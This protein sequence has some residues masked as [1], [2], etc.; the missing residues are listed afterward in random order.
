MKGLR[1]ISTC[2]PVSQ[3]LPSSGLAAALCVLAF[4]RGIGAQAP[5]AADDPVLVVGEPPLKQSDVA[6]WQRLV[7]FAFDATLSIDQRQLLQDRLVARWEG[8]GPRAR[9][10]VLRAKQVWGEVSQAIGPQR[11]VMRLALR[12]RMV[13]EAETD[14]DESA[15]ELLLGLWDARSPVLVPGNPPLRKASADALISLFEW[16]A[17]QALGET[18]ELTESERDDMVLHLARQYPGSAPGDRMLLEHTEELLHWLQLEWE[19]ASPETRGHFRGNLAE[20]F[21]LPRPLLPPPFAGET[22]AWEHPDG[23]F[24]VSFPADWPVRYSALPE[25]AGIAGWESVDVTAI[26][27]APAAVLELGALPEAGVLVTTVI[28]PPEAGDRTMTLREQLFAFSAALLGM[29][30]EPEPLAQSVA[31]TGAALI[32]WKHH[33]A[34]GEYVVWTSAARLPEPEGAAVITVARSPAPRAEEYASAFARIIYGMRLGGG[35][36]TD[37]GAAGFSD[38]LGLPEPREVTLDLFSM[39]L[40]GQMDFVEE[41]TSGLK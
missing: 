5:E 28:L 38:L 6:T 23:L 18:C 25:D 17:S 10:E 15:N 29:F 37:E 22:D 31:G 9:A 20:L 1:G 26:G 33:S 30:G 11:E 32:A 8:A 16:L 35:S 3:V 19:Q 24:A 27:D 2:R 14:P 34:G 12:E 4:C 41:L 36:A 13:K 39:P 7:E 40:R 21:A